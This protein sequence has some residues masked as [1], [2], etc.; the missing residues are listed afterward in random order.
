[1]FYLIEGV[2]VKIYIYFSDYIGFFKDQ[3]QPKFLR[4]TRK[5][6]VLSGFTSLSSVNV[7][8]Y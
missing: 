7:R 4:S 8:P 3:Y 5:I 1:M 2:L 6:K